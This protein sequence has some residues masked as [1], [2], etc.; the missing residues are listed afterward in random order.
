MWPRWH[1]AKHLLVEALMDADRKDIPKILKSF[2]ETTIFSLHQTFTVDRMIVEHRLQDPE[3]A[4]EFWEWHRRQIGMRIGARIIE[5]NLF[6]SEIM[7][8]HDFGKTLELSI[9]IVGVPRFVQ[10][11]DGNLRYIRD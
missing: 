4:K 11:R 10:G 6:F 5:D 3:A 9:L 7:E 2:F 1:R 8:E